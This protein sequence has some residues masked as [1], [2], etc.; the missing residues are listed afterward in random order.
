MAVRT[1]R[2][3]AADTSAGHTSTFENA[4]TRGDSASRATRASP[5]ESN[6]RYSAKS[7]S[8]ERANVSALGE[9]N[10]YASCRCG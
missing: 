1:P 6:G 5:R 2:A 10:V 8:R 7:A 9:K 4:S 3:R